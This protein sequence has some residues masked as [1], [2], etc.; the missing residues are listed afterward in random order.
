MHS[1]G[2]PRASLPL[3]ATAWLGLAFIQFPI[4]VIFVYAFNTEESAFSFP[5]QGFTLRWFALALGREDVRAAIALSLKIAAL[6]TATLLGAIG[7][8]SIPAPQAAAEGAQAQLQAP[9]GPRA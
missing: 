7:L 3:A 9:R 8:L 2:Q 6:S 5:L 4:L 1:E